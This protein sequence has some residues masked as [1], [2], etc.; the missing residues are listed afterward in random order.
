MARQ[1]ITK[2]DAAEIQSEEARM[3]GR[4]KNER[5]RFAAAAQSITDKN[6]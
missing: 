1:N 4:R 6:R 2:E 5:G 3:S